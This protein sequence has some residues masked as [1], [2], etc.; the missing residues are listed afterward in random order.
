MNFLLSLQNLDE[1]EVDLTGSVS[2]TLS[3]ELPL[4]FKE[5]MESTFEI[6]QLDHVQFISFINIYQTILRISSENFQLNF[7]FKLLHCL[8]QCHDSTP[9]LLILAQIYQN[10]PLIIM[11]LILSYYQR[12]CMTS[13]I[14]ELVIKQVSAMP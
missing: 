13:A 10:R 3:L 9:K 4:I 7:C 8:L 1:S 11:Q 5:L 6:A 14:F 12:S 2:G